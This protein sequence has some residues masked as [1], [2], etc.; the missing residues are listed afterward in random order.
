MFLK[1]TVPKQYTSL[2]PKILFGYLVFSYQA[3]L[4]NI[5]TGEIPIIP[6]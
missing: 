4:K 2:A 1:N 5:W 3:T 6:I